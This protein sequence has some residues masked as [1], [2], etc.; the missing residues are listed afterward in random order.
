MG[1]YAT[2]SYC[3]YNTKLSEKEF[4]QVLSGFREKLKEKNE[5]AYHSFITYEFVYHL[6]DEKGNPYINVVPGGEDYYQKHYADDEL[7]QFISQTTSEQVEL[8][9]D[10]EDDCSW[11]H[12]ISPRKIKNMEKVWQ[13]CPEPK[14]Y[15][16]V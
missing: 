13:V 12:Q 10:G 15:E 4:D 16:E 8:L 2:M 6:K 7:A 5:S 11:G 1:Y 9:F 3:E 14:D